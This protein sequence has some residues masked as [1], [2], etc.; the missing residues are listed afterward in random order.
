MLITLVLCLFIYSS[1]TLNDTDVAKSDKSNETVATEDLFADFI[2]STGIQLDRISVADASSSSEINLETF[3]DVTA[4]DKDQVLVDDDPNDLDYIGISFDDTEPKETSS[5]TEYQT[6]DIS[7]SLE[8]EEY[9]KQAEDGKMFKG[10]RGGLEMNCMESK[11]LSKETKADTN[12][13]NGENVNDSSKEREKSAELL[14]SFKEAKP[15]TFGISKTT[16]WLSDVVYT[17]EQSKDSVFT[18]EFSK[19]S[20]SPAERITD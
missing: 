19:N 3:S 15:D 14:Q 16:A 7:T 13:K 1:S 20:E 17:N 4:T 11:E 10:F 6:A 18:A 2:A 12:R 9:D 8:I 5:D